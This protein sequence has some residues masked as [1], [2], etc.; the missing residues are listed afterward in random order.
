MAAAPGFYSVCIQEN[1]FA[2]Y[3]WVGREPYR[4]IADKRDKVNMDLTP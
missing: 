4:Q 3:I 1:L 2:I